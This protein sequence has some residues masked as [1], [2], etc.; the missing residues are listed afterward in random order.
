M[1]VD[2]RGQFDAGTWRHLHAY[3][4][5]V[6]SVYEG[7]ILV[8]DSIG[9][10]SVFA[11]NN[12][13]AVHIMKRLEPVISQ[14]AGAPMHL[15]HAVLRIV[16]RGQ[17]VVRHCDVGE[18]AAET[19]TMMPI[20]SSEPDAW[21]FNIHRG[22]EDHRFVPTVGDII[23]MPDA[24]TAEHWR[25]PFDGEKYV[26]LLGS[27]SADAERESNWALTESGCAEY[28]DNGANVLSYWQYHG[29]NEA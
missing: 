17:E 9:P 20:F 10:N 16:E 14:A 21:A 8:E 22:G 1:L 18:V 2:I 19:A 5:Q 11:V 12:Y 26:S 7:D 28:A 4:E 3:G 6:R 13:V 27:L 24:K 15:R 29:L 25:E 23:V